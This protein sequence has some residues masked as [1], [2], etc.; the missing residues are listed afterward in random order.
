MSRV[1]T[2]REHAE[3]SVFK[4]AACVAVNGLVAYAIFTSSYGSAFFLSDD[5]RNSIFW[6]PLLAG[7]IIG[8]IEGLSFGA[9]N[10]GVAFLAS[11]LVGIVGFLM[12]ITFVIVSIGGA[13][14]CGLAWA[15]LRWGP[16]AVT[17]SRIALGA[18]VVVALANI[19]IVE[20]TPGYNDLDRVRN[21]AG[22]PAVLVQVD[23]EP[24]TNSITGRLANVDGCL[25][26]TGAS[27]VPAKGDAPRSVI[28]DAAAGTAVVIWPHGT[29]VESK[30][31]S[32]TSQGR[33]YKLGDEVAVGGGWVHLIKEDPFYD[34]TP[35]ACLKHIFIY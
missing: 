12:L 18:I 25:G 34:Q 2:S 19:V 29:T 5:E 4:V 23:G 10:A 16:P 11:V 3:H 17:K 14:G 1:S 8:F 26:V 15:Y 22:G 21:P 7:V 31:F 9:R 6:V 24:Y 28:E 13:A 33:A 35:K 32:V 27:P 20:V 30:P